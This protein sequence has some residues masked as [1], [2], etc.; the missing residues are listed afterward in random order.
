MDLAEP[1]IA[2][3]DAVKAGR[4]DEAIRL[5]EEMLEPAGEALS[6]LL[7]NLAPLYLKTHRPALALR[8]AEALT[9][10]RPDVRSW[11]I[12]SSVEEKLG[13]CDAA[14]ASCYRALELS[15]TDTSVQETRLYL[16]AARLRPIEARQ[17]AEEWAS[18]LASPQTYP[19]GARTSSPCL[20]VGYVSGDFRQHVMDRIIK[21]LLRHH[22]RSRF[23]ITLFDNSE[24]QDVVSGVMRTLGTDL[25]WCYI[26]G[27]RD[28]A[29]AA[30]V[31]E[32]GIDIL[33][34]LSGLTA[35]NRLGVFALRPAPIQVTGIG[36]LPTTGTD[37]FQWRL[38]D[39]EE[40][41][42]YT[43]P[44][45]HMSSSTAPEHM[46]APLTTAPC[47]RNG[48][49]TFGYINGLRKL[50]A[51][52]IQWCIM[53]LKSVPESRLLLMIPG[54]SDAETAQLILRRFD[55]VQDRIEFTQSQGGFAFCALFKDIDLAIDPAPYGGCITSFDTLYHGVPILTQK[56]DRR[57]AAD[58]WRLQRAMGLERFVVDPLWTA[59]Y[60][61][62]NP[63]RLNSL[64]GEMRG[65][66]QATAAGNPEAW[67]KELERAFVGMAACG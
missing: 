13:L 2:A 1:L 62:R 37:Y 29:V 8:A 58:A 57:I 20:R 26:R 36:Y 39:V 19:R 67:V 35:G 12:R 52:T 9:Y 7:H 41:A 53:L 32:L 63:E 61:A 47:I 48:Y 55:P 6:G 11:M 4:P 25:R 60:F 40:Q 46:G 22:D 34:D 44:L 14:L 38:S 21:P 54:A 51:A 5:Y 15:P 64:R 16:L 24:R 65:M 33:V 23:D 56:P 66:L 27:L 10:F 31:A 17:A 30:Q 28:E 18:G 50:N 49:L 42:Q 59:T 43:E 3:E 45:W